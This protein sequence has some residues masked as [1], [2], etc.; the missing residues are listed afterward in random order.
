MIYD[1]GGYISIYHHNPPIY[2]VYGEFM[3]DLDGEVI[4]Y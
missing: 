4:G 3:V 1:Y 2:H